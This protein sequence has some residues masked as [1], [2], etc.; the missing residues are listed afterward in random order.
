[1]GEAFPKKLQKILLSQDLEPLPKITKI[2]THTI[3]L[4]LATV[5]RT[6]ATNG[7]QPPLLS[8]YILRAPNLVVAKPSSQDTKGDK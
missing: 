1:M 6:L 8:G 5:C 3:P 4:E 2:K 7:V